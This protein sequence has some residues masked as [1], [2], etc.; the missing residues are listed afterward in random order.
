MQTVQFCLMLKCTF[1]EIHHLQFFNRVFSTIG[2]KFESAKLPGYIG[3]VGKMGQNK[4]CVG[5]YKNCVD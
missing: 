3:Y 2:L 5:Q 4:I 1:E